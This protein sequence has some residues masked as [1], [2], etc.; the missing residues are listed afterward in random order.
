MPM[1]RAV[2]RGKEKSNERVSRT[3]NSNFDPIEDL[4]LIEASHLTVARMESVFGDAKNQLW[5][6][7]AGLSQA[8]CWDPFCGLCLP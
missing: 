5:G 8:R 4:G 1:D 2:W 3:E 7:F 6:F